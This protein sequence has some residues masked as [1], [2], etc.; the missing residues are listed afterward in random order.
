MQAQRVTL[1]CRTRVALSRVQT[2]TGTR[3]QRRAIRGV[4]GRGSMQIGTRAKAGIELHLLTDTLKGFLVCVQTSGLH[5]RII[6]PI[7]TKPTQVIE[8]ALRKSGV[9]QRSSRFSR[10]TTKPPPAERAKTQASSA[11]KAFPRCIS[12]LGLGAM[13]PM[14][15]VPSLM[16]AYSRYVELTL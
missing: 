13:R 1:R 6:I 8:N 10:R 7:D 4:W 12:P 15:R 5:E 2:V 11:E 14:I 3:I 9:L 16:P